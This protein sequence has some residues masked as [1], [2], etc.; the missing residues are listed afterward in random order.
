MIRTIATAAVGAML[1]IATTPVLADGMAKGGGGYAAPAYSKPACAN[2]GGFYIGA[3]V[4]STYYDST[5]VDRDNAL[6]NFGFGSSVSSSTNDFLGGVQIGYNAQRGCTL[7]GVEADWSFM[8]AGDSRDYLDGFGGQAVVR[9]NVEWLGTIRTRAGLVIDNL[10]LFVTG[11]LAF[12]D[13]DKGLEV[14]PV[15]GPA[16]ATF[17]ASDTRWGWVAGFGTEYAF[18]DRISLKSEALFVRF[19]DE[20][21]SHDVPGVG[22]FR[23][24]HQDSLWVGRIGLNI[25][26]GHHGIGH[27]E[28]AAPLK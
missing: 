8:D 27:G 22:T 13:F 18:S 19:E 6:G 1:A 23:I 4:G 10:M 21:S 28:S 16:A 15:G 26:L 3:N 11:G 25:K 12:A 7:F 2:F 17:S 14:G 5:T 24:D 9:S 20:T